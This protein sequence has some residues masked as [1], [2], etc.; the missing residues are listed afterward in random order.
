MLEEGEQRY[1][2]TRATRRQPYRQG[3]LLQPNNKTP[4]NLALNGNNVTAA[5]Q[6]WG[7]KHQEENS[8]ITP[9]NKKS[10]YKMR[11]NRL[12][13]TQSLMKTIQTK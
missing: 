4:G 2:E 7:A 10:M 12:L 3:T 5:V 1:A 9:N 6:T 11:M 13:Q 8:R